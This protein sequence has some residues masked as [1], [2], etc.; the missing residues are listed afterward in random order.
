MTP[1]LLKTRDELIKIDLDKM[2]YAEADGNYVYFVFRNTE[3]IMAAISLLQLT[4]LIVN[5]A[6]QNDSGRY[7]RI[8]RKYIVDR[9]YIT[10]INI[11]KQALTLSDLDTIKPITLNVHRDA[12]RTLKQTMTQNQ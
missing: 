5:C 9:R 2:I 6:S 4:K 8:G 12:L 1:I 10:H 7:I 11:P 3:R